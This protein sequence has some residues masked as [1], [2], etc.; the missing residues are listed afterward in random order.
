MEEEKL[1]SIFKAVQGIS[2]LEW[3]KICHVIERDFESRAS[4]QKNRIEMEG[5]DKLLEK[6]KREFSL[7]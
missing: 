2:Y 5:P 4:H 1:H 7:L 6:F 3:S